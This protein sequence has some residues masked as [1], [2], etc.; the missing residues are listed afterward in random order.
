MEIT[1]LDDQA[2]EG[3]ETFLVSLKNPSEG[4]VLAGPSVTGVRLVD[5]ESSSR[6]GHWSRIVSLPA[7]AIHL[8]LLLTGKVMFWQTC[9]FRKESP[10]SQSNVSE[11]AQ[12]HSAAAVES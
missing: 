4:S 2:D 8:H 1:L 11:M 10:S 3:D 9:A 7:I 6:L 12:P 5:N